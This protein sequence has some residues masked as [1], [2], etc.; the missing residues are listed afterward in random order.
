MCIDF[1]DMNKCCSKDDFP[2][3]RIDQIIDSAAGCDIMAIT[4][5]GFVEKMKKRPIL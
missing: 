4:R 2:L 3:A 1:T 5:Y